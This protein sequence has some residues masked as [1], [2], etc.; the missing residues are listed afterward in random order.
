MHQYLATPLAEW[1][2]RW[3]ATGGSAFERL[4]LALSRLP[5]SINQLE[6]RVR[7]MTHHA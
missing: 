1:L 3:P 2:A 6:A 5:T 7:A 4:Q